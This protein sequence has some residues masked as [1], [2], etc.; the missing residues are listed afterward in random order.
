GS[1]D[2]F[3]IG[4]DLDNYIYDILGFNKYYVTRKKSPYPD[5]IADISGS[6]IDDYKFDKLKRYDALILYNFH[7][8]NQRK[9]EN[10]IKRY[11]TAG[12][13]VII[14]ASRTLDGLTN[15]LNNAFF[16]DVQIQREPLP[17]KPKINISSS[18]LARDVDESHFS[19]FLTEE[20]EIWEGAAYKKINNKMEVLVRADNKILIAIQ[21]IGN[22]KVIWVGYNMLFHSFYYENDNEK[23][24]VRNVFSLIST[25]SKIN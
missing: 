23:Q 18:I 24:L 1:Q 17:E 25:K 7:W 13:T 4:R 6:Y 12:G 20:G 21:K 19:P 16:L 2:I 11:V 14:D 10:L 15:N 3:L 8:H 9:A 22:G 5:D